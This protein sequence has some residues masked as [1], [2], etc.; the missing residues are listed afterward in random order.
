MSHAPA[1]RAGMAA[2]I[3]EVAIELGGAIGITVL[4]SV[5]AGLY[6]TLL[7]LPDGAVFPPAV[8]E[9]IDQALMVA[10]TLPADVARLLTRS[11]HQAFDGA[12]F[13]ALAI[14]AALLTAV[15]VM[16]WRM[17]AVPRLLPIM[18]P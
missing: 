12:Y 5:L 4:G 18:P 3:E 1:E 11:V 17:R 7:V 15:A 8:R 16:A 14:N 6:S 2:S 10:E 13:T 9:G